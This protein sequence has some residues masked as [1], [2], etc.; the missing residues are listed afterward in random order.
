MQQKLLSITK[1]PKD[2]QKDQKVSFV[3]C[4]QFRYIHHNK[5][6]TFKLHPVLPIVEIIQED[7]E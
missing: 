1:F 2:L 5:D 6:G 4:I 7:C 3:N